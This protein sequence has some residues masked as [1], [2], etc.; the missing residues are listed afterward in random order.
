[1]AKKPAQPKKIEARLGQ[2]EYFPHGDPHNPEWQGTD[3]VHVRQGDEHVRLMM[4]HPKEHPLRESHPE[5]NMEETY[6]NGWSQPSVGQRT[7]WDKPHGSAEKPE[8]TGLFAT[9]GAKNLVGTAV[10][11]AV[12]HSHKRFGQ[13]PTGSRDLSKDSLPMVERLNEKLKSK[14]LETSPTPWRPTND[15]TQSSDHSHELRNTGTDAF[16]NEW[17]KPVGDKEIHSANQL[18]RGLYA[19]R[20]LNKK[21]F[22]QPELPL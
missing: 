18:M 19:G 16:N 5:Y 10:G 13:T 12:E 1:M 9:T 21:Q 15:L 2:N 17:Y 6:P 3:F 11:L 7:L 8:I 22:E 4:S 20:H 14:G